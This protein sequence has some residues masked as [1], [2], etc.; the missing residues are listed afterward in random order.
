M[1]WGAVHSSLMPRKQAFDDLHIS[2]TYKRNL[3]G[4]DN[5]LCHV[6][7]KDGA[8]PYHA[9]LEAV[10]RSRRAIPD[11]AALRTRVVWTRNRSALSEVA[12]PRQQWGQQVIRR[13]YEEMRRLKVVCNEVKMEWLPDQ[14]YTEL[15]RW[16]KSEASVATARVAAADAPCEQAQENVRNSIVMEQRQAKRG[17]PQGVGAYSKRSTQLCL[18]THPHPLR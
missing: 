16:A 9:E 13:V 11:S 12:R 17:I 10:A 14:V 15:L 3:L 8:Q 5:I 6:G 7:A 2:A 1:P 4:G 18:E